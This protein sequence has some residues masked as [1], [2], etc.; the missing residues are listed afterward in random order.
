MQSGV[1]VLRVLRK[2]RGW[3]QTELGELVG[4]HQGEVSLAENGRPVRNLA[5]I[6]IHLGVN[7]PDDLLLDVLSPEG[8]RVLESVDK[9]EAAVA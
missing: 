9:L 2:R 6:A 4:L 5:L 7:D 8:Q 3:T 1:R